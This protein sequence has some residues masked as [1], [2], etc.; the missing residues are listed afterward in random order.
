M[1]LL[2]VTVGYIDFQER[3]VRKGDKTALGRIERAGK[4]AGA[5]ALIAVIFAVITFN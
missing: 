5:F 1:I 4:I 3:A 2:T